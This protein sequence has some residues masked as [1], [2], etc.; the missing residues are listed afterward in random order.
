MA[1]ITKAVTAGPGKDGLL[2]DA[3]FNGKSVEFTIEGA[4]RKEVKILSVGRMIKHDFHIAGFM[5]DR[6]NRLQYQLSFTGS[7]NPISRSGKL[8]FES[9]C[10]TCKQGNLDD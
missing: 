10:T 2:I 3:L 8:Q 7:Y 6:L 4:G 1:T 5:E 9:F